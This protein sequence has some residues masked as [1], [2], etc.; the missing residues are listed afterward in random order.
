MLRIPNPPKSSRIGSPNSALAVVEL[1]TKLLGFFRGNKRALLLGTGL[2]KPIKIFPSGVA[3]KPSI[4]NPLSALG[5]LV[6]AVLKSN[7]LAN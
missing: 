2:R 4:F 5:A 7:I 1:V 6:S 3:V